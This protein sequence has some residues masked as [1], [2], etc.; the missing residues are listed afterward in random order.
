MPDTASIGELFHEKHPADTVFIFHCEF[1]SKRGP[2]GYSPA[3]WL[4]SNRRLKYFR[5][6][7]R[8]INVDCYPQISYREIYLLEDGYKKFFKHQPVLHLYSIDVA[9]CFFLD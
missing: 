7:D 3:L 1:S 4:I 5:S 9:R 8:E 6:I 2:K